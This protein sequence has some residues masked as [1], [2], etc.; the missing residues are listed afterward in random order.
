MELFCFQIRPVSGPE[1]ADFGGLDGPNPVQNL[2]K[3]AGCFAPGPAQSS[4][5]H[6]NQ[7]SPARKPAGFENKII[8]CP[9]WAYA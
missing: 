4:L 2:S 9:G 7:P 6:Q 1:M 8:P 3:L 5:D